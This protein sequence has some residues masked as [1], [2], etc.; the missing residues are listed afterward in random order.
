MDDIHKKLEAF[1]D[2]RDVPTYTKYFSA[3][4]ERMDALLR[5]IVDLEAYP[6]KEYGSWLLSHILKRKAVD[7]LPY[8]TSLVDLLFETDDQT[9]LRNIAHCLLEI[10]VQEYRESELFDRLLGFLN[11]S[12][13]KVALHMYSIRLLMQLCEKYPELAPEVRD[14]I[15]L[16]NEGKSAAYKIGVRDFDKKFQ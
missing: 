10:G 3:S 5:C 7:G 16:N 4:A 9:V 13:N 1:R 12:S 11:D 2:S 6:Y 14:V 15:H 8:Y